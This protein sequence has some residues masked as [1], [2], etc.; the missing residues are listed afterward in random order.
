MPKMFKVREGVIIN[1]NHILYFTEN[2]VGSGDGW[3]I[4]FINKEECSVSDKEL[5]SLA[6]FLGINL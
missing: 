6:F 3:V 1:V 2:G 5:R 4:N